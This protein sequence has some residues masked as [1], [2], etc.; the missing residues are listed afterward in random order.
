MKTTEVIRRSHRTALL[1]VAAVFAL[2]GS[3]YAAA[4]GV[5]GR[6]PG[7]ASTQ[8]PPQG[9]ANGVACQGNSKQH[10][11]GIPGTPFSTCVTGLA[12]SR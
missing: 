5:H 10:V 4:A 2:G 6:S 11:P 7:R 3:G 8:P 12:S 1:A 9:Q